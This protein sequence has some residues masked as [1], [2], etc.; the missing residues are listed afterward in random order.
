MTKNEVEIFIK[1]FESHFFLKSANII[2]GPF[3]SDV[4]NK[5]FI[6][7]FLL[8]SKF[9]YKDNELKIKIIGFCFRYKNFT[10]DIGLIKLEEK[11][12]PSSAI[13][14][15]QKSYN[16]SGYTLAICGLGRTQFSPR[17]YPDVLQ[18][19]IVY[20]INRRCPFSEIDHTKKVCLAWNPDKGHSTPC[21]GDSVG[22]LFPKQQVAR[23]SVSME[24]RRM[25]ETAAVELPSIHV[26]RDTLI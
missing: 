7:N 2:T 15:C 3:S 18:E 5:M 20:E 6:V 19:T 4:E 8:L 9:F 23:P 10:N 25:E 1:S 11:V 14:L 21:I 22:P 12:S 13:P 26:S 17:K 24:L 16:D